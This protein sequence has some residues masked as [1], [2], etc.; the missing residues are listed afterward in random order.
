MSDARIRIVK[1]DAFIWVLED[2]EGEPICIGDPRRSFAETIVSI[3]KARACAREDAR[4]E[5]RPSGFAL[6]DTA[7]TIL[8][9]CNAL[10]G[11]RARELAIAW[12]KRELVRAEYC[13]EDR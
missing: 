3:T 8:A 7:G 5:R 10:P 2:A 12:T 11:P 6:V 4:Y 13:C 1:L 9:R